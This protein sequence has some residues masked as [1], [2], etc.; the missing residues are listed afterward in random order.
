M[1]LIATLKI[2]RAWCAENYLQQNAKKAKER[3]CYLQN[4]V[5]WKQTTGR[6]WLT[7]MASVLFVLILRQNNTKTW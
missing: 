3:T 4:T 2:V 7:K 1:D 6:W 5:Y